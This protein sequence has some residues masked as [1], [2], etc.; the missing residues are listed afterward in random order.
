MIQRNRIKNLLTDGILIINCSIGIKRVE[1]QRHLPGESIG[2]IAYSTI[3][4]IAHGKI[5]P[6]VYNNRNYY[7]CEMRK[8]LYEQKTLV[9]PDGLIHGND[10]S[11]IG[12]QR[13]C[14]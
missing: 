10:L 1:Y 7:F 11:V 8:R 13:R 12:V 2:T 9:Y 14:Q 5:I 3:R 4:Q 6:L